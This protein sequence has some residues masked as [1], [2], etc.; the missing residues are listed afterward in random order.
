MKVG[1]LTLELSLHSPR[2]LKEKRAILK[3]LIERIRSQ[4]NVSVA[5]LGYQD[6]WRR[7]QIGVAHISNDGGVSDRVLAKL[8][9]RVE[10]EDRGRILIES[11]RIELV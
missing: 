9:N 7:A 6:D 3:P 4:Y 11:Y 10:H 1:I 2:S 5:E 8:V